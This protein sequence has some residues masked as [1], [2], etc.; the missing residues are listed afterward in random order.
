MGPRYTIFGQELCMY[1]V[2]AKKLLK[3]KGIDYTYIDINKDLTPEQ[4]QSVITESGMRTVPIIYEIDELIG[5][6]EELTKYLN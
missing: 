2:M 5:G 6:Y 1:C 3:A 4:K